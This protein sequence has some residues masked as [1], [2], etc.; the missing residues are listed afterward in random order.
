MTTVLAKLRDFIEDGY[1]WTID[2]QTYTTSAVFT[3]IEANID[4]TSLIVYKN[5]VV[6]PISPSSGVTNYSYSATTGKVTIT[7]TLAAGDS[8]E[9]DYNA[10][11]RYSDTELRGFVRSALYYLSNDMYKTFVAK[12]DN[13]IFPTP[14]EAEE[15]LIAL[16]ANILIK[17]PIS[18]Y[19]TS[20]ITINFNETDTKDQ[21]IA[22]AIRMFK[23]TYGATSFIKLDKDISLP[24]KDED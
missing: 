16:I 9:F 7:A 4:S 18:S 13:E 23:K 5:Q 2:P 21:K 24:S 3:L 14:T 12:S 6:L 15:N 19:R 17:P 11:T 20:D 22:K 10:Y 1:K 8:L